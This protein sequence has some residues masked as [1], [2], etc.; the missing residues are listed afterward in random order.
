M[1]RIPSVA[2][3][4]R[5]ACALVVAG[6]TL[7]AHA[8]E[9]VIN[10]VHFTPAQNTYAKSF[11][12]FVDAVNAR[13]KGVVRI[14]VRGGPEVMPILQLGEAQKNGLIDMLDA[15]PGLYLNLVPEGEVFSATTKKPWELRANGGWA[16]IDRIF[17]EKANAHILAHVDAG[18]GFHVFAV[19]EPTPSADGGIDWSRLK[20][21]SAPLYREFLEAIGAVPVVQP[22]GEAY[23]S[24]ERG[25]VN[26][27]AYTVLGYASFGWDKF[28]RYRIDPSFLQTDVL[29]TMN[30]R[31]WD[32]LSPEAKK[33]LDEVAIAHE[34]ASY[35]ANAEATRAEG[36]AMIAKGMK[37]V[38]LGG[39][40]RK[41]YEDAA[42]R[43][44][45]ERLAKRDPANVAA[46]KAKFLD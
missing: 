32:A 36:E 2:P 11:M 19:N 40:A 27:N 24:L 42:A 45:W 9:A 26:A 5:I 44:S 30:K 33:L 34:R 46:L 43:T 1:I 15:A 37:V 12:K 17:G 22:P 6:A 3:L 35:E 16:L 25:L 39:A 23:T 31:K 41:R 21:R 10:A 20:V 13:G 38:T 8:E 28:T 18:T 4:S 14:Q 29:I 7:A